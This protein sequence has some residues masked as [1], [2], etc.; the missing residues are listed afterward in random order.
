MVPGAGLEPARGCPQRIL[1]PLCLPIP[2]P[3]R[4]VGAGWSIGGRGGGWQCD[5]PGRGRWED[6]NRR[7]QR[8]QRMRG[9][10]LQPAHAPDA[11]LR[12]GDAHTFHA[13][14]RVAREAIGR[15]AHLHAMNP[16]SID[17]REIVLGGPAFRAGPVVRDVRESRA[18]SDAAVRV[19]GGWI[20][21]VTTNI[22]YVL[23]HLDGPPWDGCRGR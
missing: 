13:T 3:R 22:T 12:S 15:C 19:T 1:S 6:V 16:S 11:L 9:G 14:A 23:L 4:Q 2:P 7:A 10:R 21:D 5:F 17:G 20:V 8:A 18:G